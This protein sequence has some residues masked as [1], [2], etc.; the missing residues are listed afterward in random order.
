MKI[1][2][3]I[4]ILPFQSAAVCANIQFHSHFQKRIEFSGMLETTMSILF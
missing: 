1:H 4:K 3:Y 2:T